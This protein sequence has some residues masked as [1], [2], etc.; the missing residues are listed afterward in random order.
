MTE[1]DRPNHDDRAERARDLGMTPRIAWMFEPSGKKPKSSAAASIAK[2]R[3]LDKEMGNKRLDV[4]VR[5]VVHRNA[6]DGWLIA[7]R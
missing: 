7:D 1:S 3:A 5:H 6:A 2:K 4:E